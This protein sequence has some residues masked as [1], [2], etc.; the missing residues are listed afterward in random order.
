MTT[1]QKNVAGQKVTMMIYQDDGVSLYPASSLAT[2]TANTRIRATGGAYGA[3]AGSWTAIE[4]GEFEYTATQGE[5][6]HDGQIMLKV[7][8]AGTFAVGLLEKIDIGSGASVDPATIVAAIQAMS[9][10]TGRTFDGLCKRLEAFVANKYTQT[11]TSPIH[12]KFY[13]VDGVTVAFEGDFDPTAGTRN[14]ADV[15]GSE[16]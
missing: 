8:L 2:V 14:A 5:T 13:R 15:T 1:W 7:Q 16:P 6:N 9:H 4:D 12:R 3:I 10:D 11:G